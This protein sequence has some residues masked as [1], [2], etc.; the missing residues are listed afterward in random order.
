MIGSLTL[1]LVVVSVT[2]MFSNSKIKNLKK[3]VELFETREQIYKSEAEDCAETIG[4]MQATINIQN[5]T[6]EIA[7]EMGRAAQDA[8][9]RA[10]I[11]ASRLV[12]TESRVTEL[13]DD[14]ERFN[15]LTQSLDTCETY[16]AILVSIFGEDQ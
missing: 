10:D 4:N 16:E 12:L 2:L 11:L 14:Q 7:A 9:V 15:Q 6:A 13:I 1:V 5:E 8:Q 3:D